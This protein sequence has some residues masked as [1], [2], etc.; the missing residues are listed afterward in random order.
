[1]NNE[2]NFISSEQMAANAKQT[3]IDT[4]EEHPDVIKNKEYDEAK[5]QKADDLVS[6]VKSK[7]TNEGDL[8]DTHATKD[9]EDFGVKEN[10]QDAGKAVVTG[11]QNAWNNT[12]DLGKYFDAKFY[13]ERN[14]GQDPY[15]FASGL[16]FNAQ[17]MPKTRWGM[18]LRD[19]V[20]VSAGFVGVGKIGMG[21]KGIRGVM[22]AGKTIDKAGKIINAPGKIALAKRLAV[23]A[24][25]GAAVDVWDSTQTT[26]EGIVEG[27]IKSNPVLAQNLLQLEDGRDLSPAHRTF[28]NLFESMGIGAAAGAALEGAGVGY[29]KL[30]GLPS[31][32]VTKPTENIACL[33][34]TSDAAD[35]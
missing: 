8:K 19:F 26:E 1:M 14:E 35:E 33:L 12:I 21:I 5:Q 30:K 7:T 3:L 32:A 9:A 6:E 24:G 31:T 2:L 17:Q 23:D 20:D 28:L 16:K 13:A 11:V 15:S 4:Q 29:R 18:F 25:K 27:L 34:Y 10:L 22:M